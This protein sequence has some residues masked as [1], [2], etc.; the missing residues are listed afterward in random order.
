MFRRIVL[1]AFIGGL[2]AGL[3]LTGLQ[4]LQVVPII[5]EAETYE[6]GEAAGHDHAAAGEHRHDAAGGIR[7]SV[8]SFHAMEA[9]WTPEDGLERTLYSAL[10]NIAIGIGFGLLLGAAFALR[11]RIDP[12]QGALWGLAG[13]AVFFVLPALGLHPEIPGDMAAPLV[14]RQ[15]WWLL[16]VVC[17]ATGLALVFLRRAWGWKIGGLALLLIPHVIG[18]PHPELAGGIAPRELAESFVWATALAN[19]VFWVV[20]GW[21]TALSF[22]KL[23]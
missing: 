11:E 17:S 15:G 2:L 7:S 12:I 19:G 6:G 21:L 13:Y 3:V 5:L 18:A 10:A 22:R 8:A 1:S 23:A 4:M 16:T 14:D 20:L 9:E